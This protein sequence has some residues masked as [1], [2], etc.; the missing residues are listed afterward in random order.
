MTKDPE[1]TESSKTRRTRTYPLTGN[2]W[3]ARD[4][5]AWRIVDAGEIH[6]QQ[7][8]RR[9]VLQHGDEQRHTHLA[10]FLRRYTLVERRARRPANARFAT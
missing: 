2:T 5:V 7:F 3:A 8:K 4:G 10:A 6:L 1:P 9:I